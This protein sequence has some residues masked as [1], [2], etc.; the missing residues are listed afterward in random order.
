LL[1]P[2]ATVFG[3]SHG[4]WPAQWPFWLQVLLAILVLDLGISA[5]HHAS[6]KWDWLWRFHAVHHGVKRLYGFNGLT[7]HPVHQAIE[8]ASGFAPLL[9]LGVPARVATA[10][11]FCVSI[12]L[13]LQHSN[14]DYRT[15][16]LR[17]LLANAEVHRFHHRKGAAM[18]GVNFGLFTTMWD[19][20]AG[21]FFY[22]SAAA[23]KHR[24]E[25]GLDGVGEYPQ[26]YFAQ[27]VQPFRANFPQSAS[28]EHPGS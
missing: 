22:R 25:L 8:A 9:V 14:A 17:Y 3:R 10:L 5:A 16:P 1:L 13:L 12:Q 24:E 27:L 4:W 19:H 18:G 15:G 21:T 6:H 2:A 23:P 26:E 28:E 11:A 7:K 20:L